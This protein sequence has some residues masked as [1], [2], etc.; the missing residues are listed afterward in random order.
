MKDKLLIVCVDNKEVYYV[1]QVEKEADEYGKTKAYAV[2]DSNNNIIHV[3]NLDVNAYI[4]AI[5]MGYE[6][7]NGN[8]KAH[9][10]KEHETLIFEDYKLRLRIKE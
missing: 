10:T 3:Y 4:D 9:Y 1:K 7:N 6:G 5:E 8:C 2:F